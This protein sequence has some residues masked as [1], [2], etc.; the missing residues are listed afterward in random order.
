M[1]TAVQLVLIF[2]VFSL[3]FI[4]V[5][6][7]IWLILILRGIKRTINRFSKIGDEVEETARFVKEKVKEGFGAVALLTALNSLWS[8]K[9]KVKDFL[10]NLPI[11][12]EKKAVIKD[13][14][15][16]STKR[17]KKHSSSS[18]KKRRFFFKRR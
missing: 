14:K 12:E 11:K 4:F 3:I 2:S 17:E 18:Q 10:V 15:E 6:V 7:G 5:I 13:E 1:E 16:K 9:G 8:K